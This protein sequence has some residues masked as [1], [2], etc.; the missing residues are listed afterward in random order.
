MSLLIAAVH[1][2]VCQ[3]AGAQL[4]D[5]RGGQ[6]AGGL[7]S[8]A[9]VVWFWVSAKS[10]RT[11]HACLHTGLLGPVPHLACPLCQPSSSPRPSTPCAPGQ[12]DCGAHH[13]C[14]RHNH[15]HGHRSVLVHMLGRA[16]RQGCVLQQQQLGGGTSGCARCAGVA[17]RSPAGAASMSGCGAGGRQARHLHTS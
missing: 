14:D 10:L 4:R 2:R 5:P 8:S 15:R 12:A 11:L 7:L 16:P 1:R 9:I 3:H 13:P 17:H 6:A